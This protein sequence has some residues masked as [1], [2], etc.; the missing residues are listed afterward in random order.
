MTDLLIV[1]PYDREQ[2][3]NYFPTSPLFDRAQLF[4]QQSLDLAIAKHRDNFKIDY[5]FDSH[6][7]NYLTARLRMNTAS[8]SV[9]YYLER[10]I[11]NN[12]SSVI[13]VGCGHNLF[14]S[15]IPNLWGIDPVYNEADEQASF[16]YQYSLDHAEQYDAALAVNSLHFYTLSEFRSSLENF[17]RI[18]KPGGRGFITFNL[19]R[20]A[21]SK[22]FDSVVDYVNN[23]LRAWPVKYLIVDQDYQMRE[24]RVN[25]NLRIVF[26]K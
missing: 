7:R 11:E 10:L 3:E 14:K 2:F 18:I 26:E 4:I 13:D 20:L 1:D 12:P 9:F 22:N 24:C 5:G 25:G 19:S 6:P 21:G 16:D 23:I 17:A 15:V 8:M